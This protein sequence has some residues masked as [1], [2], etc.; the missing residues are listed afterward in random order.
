MGV[1]ELFTNKDILSYSC[2]PIELKYNK[3]V[4]FCPA[5]VLPDIL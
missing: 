2:D 4:F 5:I 3:F 1:K